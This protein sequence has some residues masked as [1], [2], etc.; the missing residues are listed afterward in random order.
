MSNALEPGCLALVVKSQ[1]GKSVDSIVQCIGLIQH[2][3][4][5]AVWRVRSK[6]LLAVVND[7]QVFTAYAPSSWLKKIQPGEL[8]KLNKIEKSEL[9]NV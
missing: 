1:E 7:M 4:F 9:S 2:P 6:S 5:G 8:D 3:K